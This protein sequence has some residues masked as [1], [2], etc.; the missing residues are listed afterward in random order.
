MDLKVN[1]VEWAGL[2]A[3]EQSR[4]ESIIAGYFKGA[5]II[6][7]KNTPVSGMTVA[8]ASNPFCRILCT[9][10]ESA[11]VVACGALGNPIAIAICIAAAHEAGEE[12]RKNC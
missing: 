12:C 9:T 10:A 2:N 7:D 5:R 11:A 4:I 8:A 3:E 1:D 6:S